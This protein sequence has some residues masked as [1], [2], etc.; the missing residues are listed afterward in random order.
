MENRTVL[1]IAHRLSTVK[2]R[3][4]R[5]ETERDTKRERR[6]RPEGEGGKRERVKPLFCLPLRMPTVFALCFTAKSSRKD[7]T[8]S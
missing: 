3:A 5:A 7:P 2:V 1:V 8:M 6:K 4:Q